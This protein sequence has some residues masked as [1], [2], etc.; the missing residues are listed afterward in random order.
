MTTV[1]HAIPILM[2]NLRD[3]AVSAYTDIADAPQPTPVGVI[4]PDGT[5]PTIDCGDLLIVGLTSVTSAFQGPPE[6]CAL[7]L[8]VNL[9]LTVTRCVPN[10]DSWGNP[11]EDTTLEDSALE[12][13]GDV[14]TVWHGITGRCAQNR[15]WEGYSTLTC[16]DTTF[17]DMRAGIGGNIAWFTWPISVRVTDHPD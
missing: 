6:A 7:V 8:Q 2:R 1:A 14:S 12:L 11:A 3:A 9:A 17:R 15:L 4:H 10:L 5:V 13:A 16:A